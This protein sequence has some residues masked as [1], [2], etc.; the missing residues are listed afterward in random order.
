MTIHQMF[1]RFSRPGAGSHRGGGDVQEARIRIEGGYQPDTIFA[2]AGRPLRLTFYR[3]ET[4]S[5]SERVVFPAF[6]LSATL[7]PFQEV[8]LEL[9]PE[10]AGEYEFTCGMGMLR[11]RL[12]VGPAVSG[13]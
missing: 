4:A 8:T 13:D 7:P 3:E 10:Q 6:G 9:L 5:C 12:V 1:E 2:S 11:G